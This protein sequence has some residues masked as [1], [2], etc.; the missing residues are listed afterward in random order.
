MRRTTVERD[1]ERGVDLEKKGVINQARR[2][3]QALQATV[4]PRTPVTVCDEEVPRILKRFVKQKRCEKRRVL[5]PKEKR[6]LTSSGPA[7][8]S[9]SNSIARLRSSG[10]GHQPCEIFTEVPEQVTGVQL[11]PAG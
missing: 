7:Q 3:G 8:S 10:L 11:R 6:K 4:E 9:R 1:L 2:N 5:R